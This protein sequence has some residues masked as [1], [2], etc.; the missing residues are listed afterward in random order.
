MRMHNSCNYDPNV[1]KLVNVIKVIVHNGTVSPPF[2]LLK[3]ISFSIAIWHAFHPNQASFVS[4]EL[5][6]PL[7]GLQSFM[8][9]HSPLGPCTK[10]INSHVQKQRNP[11]INHH[12]H[13]IGVPHR[14]NIEH[15]VRTIPPQKM[16]IAA[17]WHLSLQCQWR[18][19][20]VSNLFT[21]ILS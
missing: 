5:W 9:N 16:T 6:C 21:I 10:H 17:H 18:Q 2:A 12:H 3:Q 4:L 1:Q 7:H 14:L 13:T 20:W 8:M 11:P 15:F 19:N